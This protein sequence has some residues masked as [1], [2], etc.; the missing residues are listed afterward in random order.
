MK[1]SIRIIGTNNITKHFQNQ[2]FENCT[3]QTKGKVHSVSLNNKKYFLEIKETHFNC[4]FMLIFGIITD[5]SKF[6]GN[7]ALEFYPEKA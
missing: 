7:I 1:G 3:L 5:D 6:V 2:I 4:N